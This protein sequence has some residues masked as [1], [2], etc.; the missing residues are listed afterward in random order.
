MHRGSEYDPSE[1]G[2][3]DMGNVSYE[4]P[5]LHPML[6]IKATPAVNHQKE[7]AAHTLTPTGEAAIRDGA[8]AMAM[9]IIDL[10]EG[11]RWEEL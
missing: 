2:S 11:D 10:A 3:T 7:F 5:T 9:T 8:L 1:T 4:V 6:D